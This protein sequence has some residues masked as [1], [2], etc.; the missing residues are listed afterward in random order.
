MSWTW[1]YAY[2]QFQGQRSRLHTLRGERMHW[3]PQHDHIWLSPMATR[4]KK[5][6]YVSGSSLKKG[7]L[8]LTSTR[9]EFDSNQIRALPKKRQKYKPHALT[10]VFPALLSALVGHWTYPMTEFV[11]ESRALEIFKTHQDKTCA[12]WSNLKGSPASSRTS[13]QAT[14]GVP[15]SLIFFS[16]RWKVIPLLN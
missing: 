12:T 10:K 13:D 3:Y 9:P 11:V 4:K 8:A 2:S 14:P 16:S 6:L 15:F 1:F 5:I 7:R